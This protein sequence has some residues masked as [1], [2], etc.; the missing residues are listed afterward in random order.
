MGHPAGM[1]KKLSGVLINDCK[2]NTWEYSEDQDEA[3]HGRLDLTEEL[4]EFFSKF[5]MSQPQLKNKN[6]PKELY[7]HLRYIILSCP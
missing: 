4:G 2:L 5:G 6:V 1:S 3:T 7:G